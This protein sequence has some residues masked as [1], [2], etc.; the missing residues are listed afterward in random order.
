MQPYVEVRGF[1]HGGNT[2]SAETSTGG[3]LTPKYRGAGRHGRTPGMSDKVTQKQDSLV[4]ARPSAFLGGRSVL[5]LAQP[6]AAMP[7]RCLVE[8]T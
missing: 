6:T 1:F 5:T 7:C 2:R 4:I 8:V 3:K